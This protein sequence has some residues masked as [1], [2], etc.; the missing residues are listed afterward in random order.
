MAESVNSHQLVSNDV[1]GSPITA[2]RE[3]ETEFE[4]IRESEDGMV[5]KC[6]GEA[7]YK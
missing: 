3:M 2:E 7:W 5:V 4:A 1:E 6:R